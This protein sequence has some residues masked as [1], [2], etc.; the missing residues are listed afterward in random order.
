MKC[1]LCNSPNGELSEIYLSDLRKT[2]NIIKCSSCSLV[3]MPDLGKSRKHVYNE[4]YSVW[5]KDSQ[6]ELIEEAKK[7]HFKYLLSKIPINPKGKSILDLGTGNGYLMEIAKEMGYKDAYGL[8]LSSYAAALAEKKF[9]GH[10]FRCEVGKLNTKKRFDV[11]T[12]TDILEHLPNIAND[13][14]VIKKHLKKG[15][16]I[17]ITT[18]NTGSITKTI[19]GKKWFQYKYEHVVYFNK[20]SMRKLLKGFEIIK[21]A[22]NTKALNMAYYKS[23][24][25]KY[26]GPAVSGMIPDA[27]G[28]LKVINPLVGELLVIARKK[29]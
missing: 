8:E 15:G 26:S 6:G 18:P 9:P 20:K 22:S 1:P 29:A 11:I 5:G 17:V 2:A 3:Y 25:K 24:L 27:L 21:L 14:E 13:F 10:I 19:L 7:T 28:R 16:I 12:M 23:Y 4:N